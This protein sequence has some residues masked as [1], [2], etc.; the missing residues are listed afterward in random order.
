MIND[1]TTLISILA[2]ATPTT[3]VYNTTLSSM[4]NGSNLTITSNSI[5]INNTIPVIRENY[6]AGRFRNEQVNKFL[7][8]IQ[9]SQIRLSQVDF[10]LV[11]K[12]N[13]DLLLIVIEFSHCFE[14]FKLIIKDSQLCSKAS[15]VE[16]GYDVQGE[17]KDCLERFM[18]ACKGKGNVEVELDHDLEKGRS[19]NGVQLESFWTLVSPMVS[20]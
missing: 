1:T 4:L 14:K 5:L 10:E 2:E 12:F 20:V 9:D 8:F 11:P 18:V 7:K 3:A 15:N 17:V 13:L 6:L 16:T 19:V